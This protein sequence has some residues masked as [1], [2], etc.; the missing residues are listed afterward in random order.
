MTLR[1]SLISLGALSLSLLSTFAQNYQAPTCD[2]EVVRVMADPALDAEG[3]MDLWKKLFKCSSNCLIN[4]NILHALLNIYS[5]HNLSNED[6]L[7]I[8]DALRW[9]FALG[10]TL[11]YEKHNDPHHIYG[12][13][14]NEFLK[15]RSF[16]RSKDNSF[17]DLESNFNAAFTEGQNYYS[18]LSGNPEVRDNQY[19]NQLDV[20]ASNSLLYKKVIQ[21]F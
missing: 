7:L 21:W 1:K 12:D 11:E 8:E 18:S 19:K 14:K 20:R 10:Y 5:N 16:L 2:D 6:R 4:P 9:G 13:H 3:R 15:T 17:E